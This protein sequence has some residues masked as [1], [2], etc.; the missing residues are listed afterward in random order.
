MCA[1]EGI[2]GVE[3]VTQSFSI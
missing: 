3:I 2:Y 1:P